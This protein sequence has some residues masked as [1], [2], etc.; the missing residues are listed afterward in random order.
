MTRTGR[1]A[2]IAAVLTSVISIADAVWHGLT[3]RFLLDDDRSAGWVMA[4]SSVLLAVTFALLAA[5]LAEQADR[6][7]AGSRAIRWIRRVMLGILAV[8]SIVCAA[9][10]AVEATSANTAIYNAWGAVAGIGF[11]LMFLVGAVLGACLLRRLDLRPAARLMAASVV[12]IPL[13]ILVQAL[14]PGWAHPAY[15]ETALYIGLALL[16]HNARHQHPHRPTEPVHHVHM[17]G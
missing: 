13:T 12:I 6:I 11:V 14:V 16:G 9:R 4:S 7:D 1:A 10:L 5:V 17:A 2:L 8:L 3:G 15:A